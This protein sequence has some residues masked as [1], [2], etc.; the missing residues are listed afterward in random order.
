MVWIEG[1]RAP[2]PNDTIANRASTNIVWGDLRFMCLLSCYAA[3]VPSSDDGWSFSIC[4]RSPLGRG[5][6]IGAME[7]ADDLA[8]ASAHPCS[9]VLGRLLVAFGPT[10]R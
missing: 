4:I 3:S 8:I 7:S 2:M 10:L 5:T 9:I 1:T 6:R